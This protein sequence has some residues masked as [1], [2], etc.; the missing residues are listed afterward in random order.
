VPQCPHRRR[1]LPSLRRRR[2]AGRLPDGRDRR[3]GGSSARSEQ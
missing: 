2:G 1:G 3:R